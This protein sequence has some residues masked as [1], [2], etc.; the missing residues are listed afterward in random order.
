MT[1]STFTIARKGYDRKEV[2]GYIAGIKEKYEQAA[3]EQR[4]RIEG[5]KYENEQLSARVA[6][7]ES[8]QNS[9]AKALQNAVEQAEKIEYAAKVRYC[10]EGERLKMFQAKWTEYCMTHT[11]S[12]DPD[13][14]A[15][16]RNYLKDA[17]EELRDLMSSQLNIGDYVNEASWDYRCESQRVEAILQSQE[18]RTGE[19]EGA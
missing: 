17:E 18:E 11:Q 7:L 2:D 12:I 16:M 6:D 8:R 15:S 14:N 1:Q 9:V 3:I 10:L 4:D 19:A 13:H 5:L